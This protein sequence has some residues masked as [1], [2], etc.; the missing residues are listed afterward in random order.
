MSFLLI[1]KNADN[2]IFAYLMLYYFKICSMITI[3][4]VFSPKFTVVNSICA[5]GAPRENSEIFYLT[6][7]DPVKL[8]REPHG[9]EA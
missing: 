9:Q 7:D 6:D 3:L 2:D 4:Y 8:E 1:I 5:K